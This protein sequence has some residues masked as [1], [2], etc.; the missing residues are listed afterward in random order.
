MSAHDVL[1]MKKDVA[2]ALA[3]GK[4]VL[5]LESTIISHGLPYPQNIEIAQALERIAYENGVVPATICLM[6]GKI[7]IGIN[8]TELEQLAKEKNVEKVSRRDF[9]YVL[10]EKK[11]GATTVAA[12]MIA[13]HL[14]GIKVF[15]TGGIGGVHRHAE[16]TFDISADLIELSQTPVIVISAGVKAIL[17][18][19]KTLEVLETFGIP[20]YGYQTSVF[21]AFYSADSPYSTQQIDKVSTI[22]AIYKQNLK[23]GMKQGML[24]ANPIPK[25]AEIPFSEMNERIKFAIAKAMKNKI[26]GKALT[27]FLL[28]ELVEITGGKSLESNLELVKNNVLLGCKIAIQ[29]SET[30]S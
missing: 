4:P 25:S 15:A 28:R 6:N 30:D 11:V 3:N 7:K 19:P 21:P 9:G 13:A 5:A 12:T 29:L 16:N 17:D 1:E 18:I 14:A 27:P 10:A 22:A 20:V 24:I 2:E 8:D 26:S 23:M